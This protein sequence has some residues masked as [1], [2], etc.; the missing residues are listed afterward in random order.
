MTFVCVYLVDKSLKPCNLSLW[1]I[2]LMALVREELQKS[3][4][5]AVKF[6]RLKKKKEKPKE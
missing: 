5:T 4:L 1:L 6:N 3:H 2:T